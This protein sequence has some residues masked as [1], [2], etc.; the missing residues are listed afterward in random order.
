M[1]AKAVVV[2]GAAALRLHVEVLPNDEAM[3]RFYCSK[4]RQFFSIHSFAAFR[5]K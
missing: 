3:L 2:A 5:N 4:I 1:V